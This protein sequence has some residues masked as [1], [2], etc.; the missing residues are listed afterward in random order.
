MTDEPKSKKPR[1]PFGVLPE[2][3][4][5]ASSSQSTAILRDKTRP[6]VERMTAMIRRYQELRD[7]EGLPEQVAFAGIARAI[8]WLAEERFLDAHDKGELADISNDMRVVE[9]AHGLKKGEF[10]TR[11][12]GPA[13]WQ[14]LQDDYDHACAQITADLMSKMGENEMAE[15]YLDDPEEFDHRCKAGQR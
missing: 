15:L 13:E 12:E 7:E 14:E 4:M 2:M 6:T 1:R 8:L 11:S 10:W 3:V 9:E 5:S